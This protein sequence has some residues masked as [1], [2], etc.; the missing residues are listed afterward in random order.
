MKKK[1][2]QENSENYVSILPIELKDNKPVKNEASKIR[3]SNN[4]LLYSTQRAD[5]HGSRNNKTKSFSNHN[6]NI[7]KESTDVSCSDNSRCVLY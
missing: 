5:F 7:Q 1:K 3:T 6:K 4:Y 2:N